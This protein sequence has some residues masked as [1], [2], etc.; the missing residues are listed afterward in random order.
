MGGG[1]RLVGYFD[2]HHYYFMHDALYKEVGEYR[3]R[4]K[5][6]AGEFS[7]QT[8]IRELH[9]SGV[10]VPNLTKSGTHDE[11][12]HRIRVDG[13]SKYVLKIERAKLDEYGG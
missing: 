12:K 3:S 7:K 11:K 6:R 2:D 8:I 1:D 10:L 4:G 9:R 13:V 5:L